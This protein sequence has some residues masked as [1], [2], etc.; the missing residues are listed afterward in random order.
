MTAEHRSL[1]SSLERLAQSS[2]GPDALAQAEALGALFA[3]HVGKENDLL[4]PPLQADKTV[5]LAQLLVQMHRLTE[6]AGVPA[7]R[8]GMGGPAGAETG[9][10]GPGDRCAAPPGPFGDGGARHLHRCDQHR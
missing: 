3:T 1:A 6:A 10:G 7:R 8:P 5:D 9:P 4:L 2:S